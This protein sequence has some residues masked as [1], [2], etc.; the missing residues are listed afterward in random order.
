MM[1]LKIFQIDHL[2]NYENKEIKKTVQYTKYFVFMQD[3]RK[4]YTQNILYL[5][6]T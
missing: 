3:L 4:D 6:K 5:C 1:K 2:Y